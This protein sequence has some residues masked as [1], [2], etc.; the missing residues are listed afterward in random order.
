MR[1]IIILSV[2]L[3]SAC[4]ANAPRLGHDS[5]VEE[6]PYDQACLNSLYP[7]PETVLTL[8]TELEL[9]A[10]QIRES[11]QLITTRDKDAAGMSAQLARKQ[12]ALDYLHQ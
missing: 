3:I 4:S 11:H 2:A 8:K 9:T 5:T 7:T 10:P 12:A 1:L 6:I